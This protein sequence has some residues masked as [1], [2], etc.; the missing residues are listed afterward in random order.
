[1]PPAEAGPPGLGGPGDAD[2]PTWGFALDRFQ[3]E[4][5]AALDAGASVLVAAPTGSGKTVVAEHAVARALAA[6]RKAFYTTPIKALS[7]QKY[8]DLVARHGADAVGLLTGDN[9]INGDAPVVVMTTEVLRNMMYARSGALDGLLHVVLDEVHFLQD[10][11]RGPVWE[12]VITHLDPDVRLV[13]LSAT[14]SNAEEVADWLRTVR[15]PTA[16][17]LETRRPVPL[18]DTYL[19]EDRTADRLHHLPVL[20]GDRPNPEGSRFDRDV[21]R[22]GKGRGRRRYATPGRLAVVDLLE[23]RGLLPA[24]AFV[25]SRNGCDDAVRSCLG[26]GVRLTTA[27]ERARCRAILDEHVGALSDADLDVLGYHELVSALE[28]GV[29]AHHAGMVPPFKEAVEACFAEGLVKVVF[30]TETLALGVNLPARTVVIEKLTKFTGEGHEFLTP[31][32]YTQLTGRAG[33]RGIDRAGTAVVLWSP[34]VDFGQVAGLAASRSFPLTSSFRPTYNMAVNLVRRYDAERAHHLLNLSLAQ[35][36]ADRAVVDLEARLG[37]REAE[38]ARVAEAATCER[39]DVAEYLAALDQDRTRAER[40]RADDRAAV[41]SALRRLSPG[42]VL[43]LPGT[44]SGGRAAVLSVSHRRGGAVR[45]RVVTATRKVVLLGEADFDDPPAPTAT[46]PLPTPFAPRSPGFQ[47]SV[48][49]A[50]HRL[51]RGGDGRRRGRRRTDEGGLAASHPVADCPDRDAHVKAARRVARLEREVQGLRRRVTRHSD[52]LA[53]RFD[54]VLALLGA[55]GHLDGWALTARGERL[56]RIFHECDLLV[57]EALEEGLFDGLDVAEAAAM[58]STFV[59]EH[60]SPGPAPPPWF[61]AG[62]LRQRWRRLERLHGDLQADEDRF[63]LPLTRAPDPGFVPLAHAWALGGDLDQVLDDEEITAG[64]F[65]RNVKQ[66]VDLLRQLGEAAPDPVTG[67]T[68]RAAADAVFR[69]VVEAS[70]VVTLG[71]QDDEA[72]T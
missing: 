62:E 23:E 40:S 56:A 55:W 69:G 71:E 13:C 54:Q 61:P 6:G 5:I 47:R 7:N 51:P 34:F 39:G 66:L 18:D 50:L 31:G 24:I 19:V 42:D 26:A 27:D 33:R 65:V 14:V 44:A 41:L 37:R 2:A 63:E 49:E 53:R 60:R 25:F 72:P 28:A 45:V 15:G 16:Y 10:A 67:A 43:D 9:A 8:H 59:Y 64:D 57:A 58:A 70:S 22:A 12:E 38:L 21:L 32:Q 3:Q 30:A 4:A 36:Q 17:V 11:Y 29:A 48:A 1:M 68:C 20:V 35:Y 46:V 52:S